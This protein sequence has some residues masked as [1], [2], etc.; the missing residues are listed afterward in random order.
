M[1]KNILNFGSMQKFGI[2]DPYFLKDPE[3]KF[4]E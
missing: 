4:K 3:L 1:R 2:F